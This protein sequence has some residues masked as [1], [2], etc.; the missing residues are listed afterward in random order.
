MTL[1]VVSFSTLSRIYEL[2]KKDQ[3]KV[4]LAKQFGLNDIAFLENW[5]HAI[6]NLRNSCA[7]H[8]RI[9]NRRF[10]VNLKLPHNTLN[11]FVARD[12]ISTI[13]P[14]KLFALLH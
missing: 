7:H 11:P 8:S 3:Q 4:D 6:A 10:I 2:I 9:W 13:K 12:V 14:N 5:L 1:E